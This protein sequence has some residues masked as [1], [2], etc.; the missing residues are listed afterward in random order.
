MVFF[1]VQEGFDEDFGFDFEDDTSTAD[2]DPNY[3]YET[4]N[5]TI[6]GII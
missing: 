3:S 5:S 2:F 1:S 4:W 6:L